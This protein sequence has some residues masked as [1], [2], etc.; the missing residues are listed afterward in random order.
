MPHSHIFKLTLCIA[1]TFLTACSTQTPTSQ[2]PKAESHTRDGEADPPVAETVP[3]QPLNGA[4]E[5]VTEPAVKHA[6]PDGDSVEDATF[7]AKM[8]AAMESDDGDLVVGGGDGLFGAG[9]GG[10]GETG[11]IGGLAKVRPTETKT[12]ER[13]IQAHT[14]ATLHSLSKFCDEEATVD[15]VVQARLKA[16]N[17]CYEKGLKVDPTIQG[18]ASITWDIGKDGKVPTVR[19]DESPEGMENVHACTK[20]VI[21]R[22]RFE[23]LTSSGCVVTYTLTHSSKPAE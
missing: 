11:R 5:E 18:T 7:E 2:E 21:K 23:A 16:L 1:L 8:Q 19:S 10:G 20:R 6:N 17:Y 12:E 3:M 15:R 9:K 22:L 13:N 14:V 4:P